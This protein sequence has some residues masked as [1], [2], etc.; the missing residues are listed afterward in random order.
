MALLGQVIFLSVVIVLS[1]NHRQLGLSLWGWIYCPPVSP[2]GS[3]E[4]GV[5]LL[6]PG[7]GVGLTGSLW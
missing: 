4:V 3:S 2:G 6:E 7:M 5:P 1:L